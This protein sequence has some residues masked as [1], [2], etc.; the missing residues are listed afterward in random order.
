M[1]RMTNT[2]VNKDKSL[3]IQLRQKL[4]VFFLGISIVIT[5]KDSNSLSHTTWLIMA[6]ST[7]PQVCAPTCPICFGFGKTRYNFPHLSSCQIVKL[8]HTTWLN[9]HCAAKKVRVNTTFPRKKSVIKIPSN[10]RM[11]FK[12]PVV[13]NPTQEKFLVYFLEHVC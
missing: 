4:P 3:I 1:V 12:W 8:S 13:T 9:C 5:H 2:G 6:A 7:L 10:E 11:V